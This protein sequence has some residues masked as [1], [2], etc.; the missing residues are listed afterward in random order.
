[1]L[2]LTFF[3]ACDSVTGSCYLLETDTG[4][5]L[6]D[7]GMFQ[8]GKELRT[9]NERPFPFSPQDIDCVV[10]THAHI[11]HSGLIPKLVRDGFKG[12]IIATRAT[13]SLCD[14]MLRDSAHIQE[15]EAEW[16]A[17]KSK[18]AGSESAAPLYTMEDAERALKQF[19]GMTYGASRELLPGLSLRFYDAGHILG[20]AI[21]EFTVQ[22]NDIDKKIVFSGD[23]G[24]RGRPIVADPTLVE[25]ADFVIVESTYGD[26]LHDATHVRRD[27]IRDILL[28]AVATKE[29]VIIPA[30]AVGRTQDVLYEINELYLAEEIPLIPV[31]IDSPLAISA[32]EVF[33]KYQ[34]YYDDETKDRLRENMSPFDY[35]GLQFTRSVED[36]KGLNEVEQGCVII[37]ASGMCEAGR[38][39]HHLKH[40]LWRAGAHILFVGYQAEG[41]LGRRIRDGEPFV[42]IF[43]EEIAVRAHVHS[44]EGLSAHADQ[45]GLLWWMQGFKN[46]LQ[47]VFVT[48]GEADSRRVF[49]D[50]LM[51]RMGVRTEV[52]A[53]Y[54][55][56]DLLGGEM[57]RHAQVL[58][59]P[60]SA[61]DEMD[62]LW[63]Q[64]RAALDGQLQ[65]GTKRDAREARQSAERVQNLL[66]QIITKAQ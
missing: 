23:L 64:A 12:E 45:Q 19:R 55:Q 66:R 14:L 9:R 47:Q 10:L 15:S 4:R 20:S 41:T 39:K 65:R 50:L 2:K 60:K 24:E 49:A 17:R 29:K 7:C 63:Q 37:S 46:N 3:G 61:S 21:A 31:Y 32:T 11:D 59:A 16:Q 52:P 33:Q 54:T 58:P 8:G 42:T 44:I 18:R 27:K 5:V 25:A 57:T 43:S 22:H 28:Q 53:C 40:N 6:I 34:E 38:I 51:G 30:F 26:R 13:S 56:Y 62:L 35:P 1:M 36:S 48:H